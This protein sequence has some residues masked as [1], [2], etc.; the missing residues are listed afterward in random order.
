MQ[1]LASVELLRQELG[2][3]Q[4]ELSRRPTAEAH[5]T[6]VVRAE[7]AEAKVVIAQVRPAPVLE[8]GGTQRRAAP[9]P[10]VV[11]ACVH[12]TSFVGWRSNVFLVQLWLAR[13]PRRKNCTRNDA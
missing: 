1:L 5:L 7:N 2:Q 10:W 12:R 9:S 6:V 4:D 11:L 3:A 13:P 8:A